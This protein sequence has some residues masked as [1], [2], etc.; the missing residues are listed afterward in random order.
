MSLPP[1]PPSA[2]P[3][4]AAL[5]PAPGE[6]AAKRR[7]EPR[8][9]RPA[10]GSGPSA[11]RA[12]WASRP[13]RWC[14]APRISCTT[15]TASPASC[16][17]GS[18]PRATSSTSWKTAGSCARR[19]TRRPSSAV[20][21]RVHPPGSTHPPVPLCKKRLAPVGS[22][23][24]GIPTSSARRSAL[25][26]GRELKRLPCRPGV[27]TGAGAGWGQFAER[28]GSQRPPHSRARGGWSGLGGLSPLV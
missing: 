20:S 18:W 10:G 28:P 13:R 23:R 4:L 25:A 21:G 22:G 2:A 24:G 6:G 7:A 27:G 3:P 8:P 1:E 5:Q 15:C 11:P 9:V 14:A 26:R 19:I 16:A 12:S 17:S